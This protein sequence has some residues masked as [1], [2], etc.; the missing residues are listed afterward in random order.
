[1]VPVHPGCSQD[2]FVRL[3]VNLVVTLAL[4]LDEYRNESLV[5]MVGTIDLA[6][7]NVM[8]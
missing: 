1:M 5:S 6:Q 4:A 8:R 7:F 3:I 2:R